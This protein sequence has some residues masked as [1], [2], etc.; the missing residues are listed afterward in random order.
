[1]KD[2]PLFTGDHGIAT[3]LLR[4][5]PAGGC[6][7]VLVR[8]ARPGQ[9]D[10]LLDECRRFCLMAGA[11]QVLAAAPTPL[12]LPV[13]YDLLELSCPRAQFPPPAP[14]V[15]LRPVTPDNAAVYLRLYAEIFRGV[16]GADICTAADLMQLPPRS[17]AYVAEAAGAPAGVGMHTADALRVVGV[18]PAHRGLGRPLTLALLARTTADIVTLQVSSANAPAM[19]L[20]TALGFTRR[21]VLSRW[22]RLTA[23]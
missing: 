16:P 2:I 20:Y 17:A 11:T 21:R 13:A 8:S 3:L 1:M 10:A 6:A 14:P 4:G 12:A 9:T 18:L 23:E 7:Y 22:Y 19:R 5:I 15:A